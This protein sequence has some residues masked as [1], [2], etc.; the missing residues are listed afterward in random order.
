[1]LDR[2]LV[3]VAKGVFDIGKLLKGDIAKLTTEECVTFWSILDLLEKKILKDRKSALR[4]RLLSLV[5][6]L[7]VNDKKGHKVLKLGSIYAEVKKEVRA[8]K[9]VYLAPMAL[10]FI[11]AHKSKDPMVESLI[12]YEPVVDA[13]VLLSLREREVMT[14]GDFDMIVQEGKPTDALKVKAPR[15]ILDLLGDF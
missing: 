14:Q 10:A 9:L 6:E 15:E 1:M 11:E 12:R 2:S 7:G 8:G 4:A 13:A 3:K 5:E